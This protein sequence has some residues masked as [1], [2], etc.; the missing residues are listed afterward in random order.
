MGAL[1][2]DTRSDIYSL[3][4]LLY[5]LL[6][7]S[8]PLE[9]A[10]LREAAYAEILRRIREEEPTK[11][12]TRLS[13]SKDALPSISAQRK[14]EPAKLTKLVRGE[15]DWIVMKSLEKD[16]TR[17]YE[18]ANG[19]AKD[20]QRYLDGDPVEA[21]PP[22]AS[23]KL[24]KFA[25]KH[26]AALTT[27]GAFAFLLVVAT[28]TSVG[29]ALWANRERV[30]A[31][32]AER[33]A[34]EEKGRAEDREQMA[35]DAVR[36]FGDVV[37][38][39][40][41][42]KNNPGLAKLR[43][44]LLKEPQAFL[45]RLRDQ[46]Q[47]DRETTTESLAR[48]AAASYDL[49]QVT[50]EIGDKQ[51][52]LRAHMES[53]DIR[54]RLTREN[55]SVKRFQGDLAWSHT[56]LGHLQLATGRSADAMA[57][58]ERARA[59]RERLARENPSDAQSRSDLASIYESIGYLESATGRPMEAMES[60]ERARAIRERLA[61][62]SPS[63]A[64]FQ[65]DLA[66]IHQSMG[67]LQCDVGHSAEA[68]G[69][70]QR[71]REIWERLV[72]ENPSVTDFQSRLAGIHY[73]IGVLRSDAN[74]T[75]GALESHERAHAIWERL[76]RENPSVTEFQRDLA[77]SHYS[78]GVRLAITA[79]QEMYRNGVRLREPSKEAEGL[80]SLKRAVAIQERLAQENPSI[81]EFQNNLAMSHNVIGI[82]LVSMDRPAEALE[83]YERACVIQE[84]LARDHPDSPDFA[85]ALGG[86]LSN[87]AGIELSQRQFDR[88]RA[89]LTRAIE[90]QRKAL[91]ANPDHPKY[92]EF[93][94]IHLTKL[95]QANEGIALDGRMAAVL[96]GKET[97]KDS[98][99]R[100][101]LA[102]WAY[103]SARYAASARLYA[104]AFEH[105][106]KL[107]DDR[108]AA[109]RY[110]AARATALAAAGQGKDYPPPGDAARAK[111]RQQALDWLKAEYKT[112]DQLLESGQPQAQPA[113]IQTVD[114]WKQDTDLA[115][116]RDAD[117]L[118]TLPADEQ[119]AWRT[120]WADVDVLLKRAVT[121]RAMGR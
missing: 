94:N 115:G 46:L 38:D 120:L 34:K 76:A 51:D 112:W 14:M 59:I 90:W 25:R 16:R 52:A 36:R 20:I 72:R 116:V 79:L 61:R 75:A 68:M 89:N 43:A 13:E 45:K 58:Y 12:S 106:P 69:S 60:Y 5:E 35:V 17:R 65:S 32:K 62:E 83:S 108:Q 18:T 57:S 74:W 55:P 39:T 8:T 118:A 37:K 85:S 84:R 121:S 91:A 103:G 4:V 110:N 47:A 78:I 21:C 71:A 73:N 117:G 54:E 10:K 6:T 56:R 19:F 99:E 95:T 22:S 97:P 11:P 41:E 24:K 113:I 77:A 1:D 7:G 2:I 40:P 67:S 15:L 33:T 88:A 104:E 66:G 27:A 80:H 96:A 119:K 86:T 53:L 111:L 42:L 3:G 81:T 70:F 48:L 49:G 50:D 100:I 107:V 82:L 23:Y 93:I 114:H 28:A 30:R 101:Q 63:N 26:C 44:T 9:R 98:A 102:S 109:H 64:P 31:V 105:D 92:R 87:I 29:L